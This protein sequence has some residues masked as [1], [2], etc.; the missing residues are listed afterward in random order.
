M[1]LLYSALTIGLTIAFLLFLIS[2][3]PSVSSYPIPAAALTSITT[4]ISY[5]SGWSYIADF[6]SVFIVLKYMVLPVEASIVL[7]NIIMWIKNSVLGGRSAS[8]T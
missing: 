6:T 4:M 5:L 8:S 7:I 1:K 3:L 2:L